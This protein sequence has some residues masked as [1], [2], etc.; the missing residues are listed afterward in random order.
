MVRVRKHGKATA[1]AVDGSLHQVEPQLTTKD[2]APAYGP[3]QPCVCGSGKPALSTGRCRSCASRLANLH[4]KEHRAE[5]RVTPVVYGVPPHLVRD[6][7]QLGIEASEACSQL[8][9]TILIYRGRLLWEGILAF[10]LRAHRLLK[11]QVQLSMEIS[12]LSTRYEVDQVEDRRRSQDEPE[13]FRKRV[14][15]ALTGDAA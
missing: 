2:E 8:R 12:A 15:V 13:Q 5:A 6:L 1:P 7:A 4:K 9:R 14:E 10:I 11:S 3:G